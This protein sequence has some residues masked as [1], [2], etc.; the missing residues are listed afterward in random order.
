MEPKGRNG[1]ITRLGAGRR[2]GFAAGTKVDISALKKI[3]FRQAREVVLWLPVQFEH[4]RKMTFLRS[5]SGAPFHL[6]D[7]IERGFEVEDPAQLRAL[8]QLDD[9]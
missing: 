9:Y 5:C 3:N 6:N 8:L 4:R 1:G 2:Q 7:H